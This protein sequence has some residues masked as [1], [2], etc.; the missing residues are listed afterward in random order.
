MTRRQEKW[1]WVAIGVMWAVSG[2]TLLRAYL[3]GVLPRRYGGGVFTFADSPTAFLLNAVIWTAT[4]FGMM[5]LTVLI[6]KGERQTG[7]YLRRWRPPIDNS[8]RR[9]EDD[10]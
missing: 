9:P 2:W 3:Y 1:V 6:W 7:E 5:A 8:I 10:R 4:F